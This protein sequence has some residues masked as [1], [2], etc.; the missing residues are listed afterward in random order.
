MTSSEL[1]QSLEKSLHRRLSVY[2]SMEYELTW[3]RWAMPSGAPICRLRAWGRPTSDNASGG[4]QMDGWR[5]PTS[6]ITEAKPEGTKLHGRTPA[7]P[8]V[9]L[10]DQAQA[11]GWPTPN[12]GPQNDTDSKWQQRREALAKKYGNNGFGMT[13]GM[14]ASLAGWATPRANDAE[15]RG[16]IAPDPRSGLPAQTVGWNTPRATDGTNGGP[17][18]SGGALPHDA[19]IAGWGTPRAPHGGQMQ[20]P[21]SGER[22]RLENQ[23]HGLTTSSLPAPT[24]SRGALNPELPRWLLGFPATWS[25]FA[26]TGTRSRSRSRPNS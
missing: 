26:P 7:D 13:L 18:Q 11:A 15:K 24:E 5:T 22:S 21:P 6:A 4:S 1:Q 8:Q 23:V 25:A 14:A 16:E 17:N 19:A 10:A 2:G 12:A 3:K 20:M 9:G